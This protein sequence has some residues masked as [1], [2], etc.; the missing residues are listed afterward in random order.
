MKMNRTEYRGWYWNRWEVRGQWWSA[1]FETNDSSERTTVKSWRGDMDGRMAM[2][3]IDEQCGGPI[4]AEGM[5]QGEWERMRQ[6]MYEEARRAT[7]EQSSTDAEWARQ[8]REHEAN[9]RKSE[10][11]SPRVYLS[12]G[13]LGLMGLPG[14]REEVSAAFKKQAHMVHPDHGGDREMMERLVEAR[15]ALLAWL[16]PE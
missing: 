12:A 14:N 8:E 11:V 7:A 16:A 9:R 5:S 3:F 15:E 10:E 13:V 4:P 6:A 2:G 1:V